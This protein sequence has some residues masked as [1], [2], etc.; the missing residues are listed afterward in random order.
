MLNQPDLA[1]L[2]LRLTLGGLML[3]HGVAKV[4][5]GVGF[6]EGMVM[7]HGMPAFVAWGVFVGEIVAPLMLILGVQVRIAALLVVLNM[8]AAIWLVHLG[9]LLAIGEHGSYRL[10]VQAFYLL[11][12]IALMLLGGGKYGLQKS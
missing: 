12:A 10:E 1:K 8:V 4:M 7:A 11:N 9:D 3:F 5:H 2:L 6:I